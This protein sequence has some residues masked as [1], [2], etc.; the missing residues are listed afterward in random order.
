MTP[1][2]QD[3]Y[4][5]GSVWFEQGNFDAAVSCF[6]EIVKDGTDRFAD[7]YNKLGIIYQRKGLSPKAASFFEKA[8]KINPAY[9]EAALNLSI[10]YNELGKYEDA[11]NTFNCAVKTVYKARKIKDTYIEGK[12]ANE[13]ALLGEQYYYL[14]RFKEAITEYKKALRLCPKYPDIITQLGLAYREDGDIEAAAATFIKAQ[15]AGPKYIP[16]F[17]HLG[18]TYYMKGFVDMAI[19]EWKRALTIDPENRDARIYL[20]FVSNSKL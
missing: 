18:I 14:G 3:L 4:E 9:T 2:Q 8:L 13:H 19:R 1:E 17:L 16:A 7:V 15:D 20:S 10:V 11:R 6:S 5:E 12:L